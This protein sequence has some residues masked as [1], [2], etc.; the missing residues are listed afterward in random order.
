MIKIDIQR[1]IDAH[2]GKAASPYR[3][4]N[5]AGLL[6]IL[7]GQAKYFGEMNDVDLHKEL[8]EIADAG[9]FRTDIEE[10]ALFTNYGMYWLQFAPVEEFPRLTSAQV[11]RLLRDVNQCA[12]TKCLSK[13]DECDEPRDY[14]AKKEAWIRN[15]L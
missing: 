1:L 6:N 4:K 15:G 11:K 9:L 5:R 12:G 3:W 13:L 8:Q 10:D 7:Q 14:T 2:G